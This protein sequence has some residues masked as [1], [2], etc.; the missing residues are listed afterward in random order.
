MPER[1]DDAARRIIR[2]ELTDA[3]LSLDIGLP[4]SAERRQWVQD[5]QRL[6]EQFKRQDASKERRTASL[7]GLGYGIL[8]TAAG[9]LLT[10]ATGALQ[11]L[12]SISTGRN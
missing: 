9:G 11:W 1:P 4:G 10:W 8:G 2:E 5:H 7:A 12:L 3:Y 6:R